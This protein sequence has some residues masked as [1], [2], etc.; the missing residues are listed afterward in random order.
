MSVQ[1]TSSHNWFDQG[2]DAYARFRPAYPADLAGFLASLASGRDMAV[3]VGCGTGQ[4]TTLLAPFFG[5]VIGVDPSADQLANAVAHEGVSYVRAPA[6]R[7]PLPDGCADLITVAQAAHWFDLPAFYTEA[8][9]VGGQGCVLALVSYGVMQLE[10]SLNERFQHF[11]HDEVG[12]YW[13]AERK[14][15]DSGYAT[16]DFPFKELQGPELSIRL[17]W[18]LE[19]FLGYVQTWSAVRRA[20][21]AGREG[22]LAAFAKEIAGSWG[23]QD[24]RRT[25]SW[26]IAMRLGRL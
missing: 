4:L 12:P 26:P 13:P 24:I 16:L 15:V 20:R 6:E 7:M 8:R 19:Q 21:E 1:A 17:D 9:R 2:G 3:D 5:A 14:L 25:V 10:P 22:M 11:Y 23:D 18:N